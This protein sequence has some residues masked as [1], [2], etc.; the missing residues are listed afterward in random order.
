LNITEEEEALIEH[1]SEPKGHVSKTNKLTSQIDNIRLKSETISMEDTTD[2]YT[3]SLTKT[4][5]NME[6]DKNQITDYSIKK[7]ALQC[8]N[9]IKNNIEPIFMETALIYGKT[10]RDIEKEKRPVDESETPKEMFSIK[11]LSTKQSIRA[12]STKWE[13]K[14]KQEKQESELDQAKNIWGLVDKMKKRF[15]ELELQIAQHF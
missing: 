7:T 2:H 15:T 9:N 12:K 8:N 1:P 13:K 3:N 10:N 5:N 14:K 4:S 6:I 11:W